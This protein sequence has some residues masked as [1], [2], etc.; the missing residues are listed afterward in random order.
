M[1]CEFGTAI[2][3]NG[4]FAS[5]GWVPYVWGWLIWQKLNL[6]NSCFFIIGILLKLLDKIGSLQTIL[7]ISSKLLD[8]IKTIQLKWIL[9]LHLIE[10]V[11]LKFRKPVDLSEIVRKWRPI[12]CFLV[13]KFEEVTFLRWWDRLFLWMLIRC[14]HGGL[15][16]SSL[17]IYANRKEC[18]NVSEILD[19]WSSTF[20]LFDA[21]VTN[22]ELVVFKIQT[23][24]YQSL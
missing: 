17:K 13:K 10:R 7:K 5:L 11:L 21:K 19:K 6:A 8:D 24:S 12:F 2:N 16:D 20:L 1:S 3:K 15:K 9:M 22:R 23:Y 18:A 4:M 14:F